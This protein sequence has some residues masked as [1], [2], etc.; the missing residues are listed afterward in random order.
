MGEQI[1]EICWLIALLANQ[2]VLI[3]NLHANGD[4][5]PQITAEEVELL[6]VPGELADYKDAITAALEA[7][8]RREVASPKA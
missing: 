6:T 5:W 2:S 7:G 3:H 4:E 1:G 8:M